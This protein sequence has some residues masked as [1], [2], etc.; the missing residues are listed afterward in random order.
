MKHMIEGI[1]EAIGENVKREGLV[2]TPERVVKAYQHWFRGYNQDPEDI[3]TAFEDGAEQYDQIVMVKDIPVYS[4]CEH[5]IAPFF[6]KAYVGY[7]PYGKIIG[8]SK[9]PRIIDIFAARLQVQERLTKQITECID[10]ILDPCGVIVVL[11]C[12]H[13]CM[14]SRGIQKPGTYTLTSAVKGVFAKEASA[15]KEFFD[16]IQIGGLE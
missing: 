11:N 7:I 16:L 15:K 4:H 5:H 1:L 9:I 12:R 3:F 6:G 10:N 14:E 8:L 2:K 13:M